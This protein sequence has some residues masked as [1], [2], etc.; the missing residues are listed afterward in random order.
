MFL[1]GIYMYMYMNTYIYQH[2]ACMHTTTVWTTGA[3]EDDPG[4]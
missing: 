2:Y 1:L 4:T 3:H